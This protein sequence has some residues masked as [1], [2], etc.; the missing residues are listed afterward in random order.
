MMTTQDTIRA[1][2]ETFDLNAEALRDNQIRVSVHKKQVAPVLLYL[3]N[4]LGFIH[5][6]HVSCV[7]WI[8]ENVFE[9]I[10]IVYHPENRLTVL[11]KTKIDREH[12]EMENMGSFWPHMRTYQRELREMFGIEF[13]GFEAPREFILEGWEEIPPMRR[14]F[15]TRNYVQR[16]YTTRP[17]REDAWSV[18]EYIT[19]RTGEKLPDFAKKY[20]RD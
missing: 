2:N 10:Y 4:Q 12:P 18:R 5:L 19:R 1:L 3:K 9:L 14:D 7:D 17:G 20:S 15:D 11:V 6:D 16:T 8:E 13:P